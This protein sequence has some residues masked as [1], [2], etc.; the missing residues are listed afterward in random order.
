[1]FRNVVI[2]E[3]VIAKKLITS[4]LGR[5]DAIHIEYLDIC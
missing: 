4:R 3:A 5:P 1:M 2:E